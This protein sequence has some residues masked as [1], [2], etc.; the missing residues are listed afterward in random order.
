MNTRRKVSWEGIPCF[1]VRKLLSQ[2][3]LLLA[4]SAMSSQLWSASN[5]SADGHDQNLYQVVLYF[6]LTSGIVYL[7]KCLDELFEQGGH[8]DH[9]C[10]LPKYMAAVCHKFGCDQLLWTFES[11]TCGGPRMEASATQPQA[12]R[13]ILPALPP[14]YVP[15]SGF[16]LQIMQRYS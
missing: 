9:Y 8:S 4:Y 1:N 5:H 2:T 3:S 12:T 13:T 16:R 15:R 6:V 14:S 11:S 10:K 7:R